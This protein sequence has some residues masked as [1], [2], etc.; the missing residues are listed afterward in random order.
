[1]V[2]QKCLAAVILQTGPLAEMFIKV[3]EPGMAEEAGSSTAR[4][5]RAAAA[6]ASAASSSTSLVKGESSSLMDAVTADPQEEAWAGLELAHK[7]VE[8]MRAIVALSLTIPSPAP[9]TADPPSPASTDGQK[10]AADAEAFS[11]SRSASAGH[12]PAPA[13]TARAGSRLG[14]RAATRGSGAS[15]R[16]GGVDEWV[17]WPAGV[18][19]GGGSGGYCRRGRQQRSG[20][21][22]DCRCP[23]E[24][25][26]RC[27]V[28]SPVDYV[29]GVAGATHHY[30][31]NCTAEAVCPKARTVRVA[32]EMSGLPQLLPISASSSVFVRVDEAKATVWRA[33][34]VG[35]E[36]TPYSGGCFVFDIYFPVTYPN[37][38]PLVNLRTT[39]GG[40]V[41]FNPNLYNCGKVCLSLL[42][43]WQ[44]GKGENWD[45]NV[46][47]MLQV[48]IS[49]QSLILVPDPYFNE[50]GYEKTHNTDAGRYLSRDYNKVIQLG[51]IRYAMIDMLKHPLPEFHTVIRTHFRLRR[52][53]IRAMLKGWVVEAQSCDRSHAGQLESAAAELDV[54]LRAL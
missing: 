17:V 49:I 13:S 12:D 9:A 3:V 2:T 37:T 54:L 26:G 53:F 20:G 25:G 19:G 5:A 36:D 42:G 46:S 33:L 35:P 48:L 50:P 15:R 23:C 38:A 31:T 4:A 40:L 39:G 30:R 14:T 51:T 11:N 34:I 1:M 28:G 29:E 45:A 47:T 32:K 21:G 8:A 6:A 16:S 18:S 41:R 43:T 10:A 44:G 7:M 52:D 27:C 22:G 24:G